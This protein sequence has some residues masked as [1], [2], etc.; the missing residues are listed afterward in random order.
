ME[1]LENSTSI[2]QSQLA[3]FNL[4]T[5]AQEQERREFISIQN[6]AVNDRR[7]WHDI[8]LKLLVDNGFVEG[9]HFETTFKINDLN[10]DINLKMWDRSTSKYDTFITNVDIKE[11]IGDVYLLVDSVI[12]SDI[13]TLQKSFTI[14]KGMIECYSLIGSYR[15]CKPKTVLEKIALKRTRCIV[16]RDNVITKADIKEYTLE[17]YKT[18]YPEA[19]VNLSV[20]YGDSFGRRYSRSHDQ[21][22]V[23]NIKFKSGSSVCLRIGNE[24]DKE[25]V[26]KRYDAVFSKLSKEDLLDM[27]SKQI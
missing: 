15:Y 24:R 27:F 20:E 1:N 23:L 22:N 4:L 21:F 12:G 6:K 2:D 26:Y 9:V 19:I 10:E 7:Y 17:K 16:E 18:L 3:L 25:Y 14:N 5:P 13:V 11:S 8:K